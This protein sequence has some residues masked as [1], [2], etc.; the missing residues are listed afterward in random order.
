MIVL[1]WNVNPRLGGITSLQWNT[2]K[3][4]LLIL[5]DIQYNIDHMFCQ[6][7]FA[8]KEPQ[9]PNMVSWFPLKFWIIFSLSIVAWYTKTCM[10]L[11]PFK[12]YSFSD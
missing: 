4:N 6:F 2:I 10:L 11:F 5:T 9:S 1:Q 8:Y 12:I 3:H 7:C